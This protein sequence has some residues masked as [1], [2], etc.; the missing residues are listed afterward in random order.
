MN[1]FDRVMQGYQ[2]GANAVKQYQDAKLES[3]AGDAYKNTNQGTATT[4]DFGKVEQEGLYQGPGN[5][6]AMTNAQAAS[7]GLMQP[8]STKTDYTL[9]GKTQSTAFTENQIE[10]ARTRA[11]ADVYANAGHMKEASTMRR[12]AAALGLTE[13]QM[14]AAQRENDQSVAMDTKLASMPK[15]GGYRNGEG[16]TVDLVARQAAF[17]NDGMSPE[18]AQ[19]ASTSGLRKTTQADQQSYLASVYL[20]GGAKHLPQYEASISK[21]AT[22]RSNQVRRDIN[23]ATTIE[24][25]NEAYGHIDDGKS[26]RS[27]PQVDPTGKPTGKFQVEAFDTASG[28]GVGLVQ[29]GKT[30]DTLDQFKADANVMA[31]ENPDAFVAH[32]QAQA[33]RQMEQAKFAETVRGN[34]AREKNEAGQLRVSQ[35][36]AANTAANGVSSR[37]LEGIKIKAGQSELD[38]KAALSTPEADRTPAQKALIAGARELKN[39]TGATPEKLDGAKKNARQVIKDY[40]GS[41]KNAFTAYSEDETA[42]AKAL[43]SVSEILITRDGGRNIDTADILAQSKDILKAASDLKKTGFTGTLEE[44]SMQVMSPKATPAAAGAPGKLTAP[45]PGAPPTG[46]KFKGLW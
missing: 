5:D 13:M 36:N 18:E 3:D 7:Y 20:A 41:G 2:F 1:N 46:G 19:A 15:I 6:G 44:A 9:G 42:G 39:N 21:A 35:G 11:G 27:V 32:E 45:A 25:M 10:A 29:A 26:I 34:A 33:Q 38:V 14:S 30:Y 43:T 22:E 4:S 8:Q 16:A 12:D 40:I 17:E 31:N 28:K 24:A 37:T 23:K